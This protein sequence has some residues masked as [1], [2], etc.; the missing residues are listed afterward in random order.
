MNESKHK[1]KQ[2]EHLNKHHT[3]AITGIPGEHDEVSRTRFQE[4]DEVRLIVFVL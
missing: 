1:G 2:L 3:N 4:H